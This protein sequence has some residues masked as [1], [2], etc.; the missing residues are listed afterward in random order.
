MRDKEVGMFCSPSTK[1]FSTN[2]Y[3]QLFVAQQAYKHLQDGGRLI[4]TSSIA[5]HMVGRNLADDSSQG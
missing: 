5:A 4:L 2:V 3:S 1:V